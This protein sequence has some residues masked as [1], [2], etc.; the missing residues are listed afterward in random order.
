MD[1]SIIQMMTSTSKTF[2]VLVKNMKLL[3]SD[4]LINYG[5]LKSDTY[6]LCGNIKCSSP[7]TCSILGNLVE[8]PFPQSTNQYNNSHYIFFNGEKE[9]SDIQSFCIKLEGIGPFEIQ[10]QLFAQYP[11]SPVLPNP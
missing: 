1:N 3:T 4:L 6:Y 5:E 9:I 8:I 2:P 11:I 10:L 7:F